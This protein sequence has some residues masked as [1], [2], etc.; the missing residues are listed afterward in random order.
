M[1]VC[2]NKA[3]NP[4]ITKEELKS[5]IYNAIDLDKVGTLNNLWKTYIKPRPNIV[6]F[7]EINEPL[8]QIQGVDINTLAFAIRIGK[9]NIVKFLI[10]NCKAKIEAMNQIY[11]SIGKTPMDVI[12]EYGHLDLLKYYLPIYLESKEIRSTDFS[13]HEDSL[14]DLSIF[15]SKTMKK[16]LNRGPT[17]IQ[18]ACERGKIEIVDY[19]TDYFK[20]K[21][22]PDEFN[23]HFED[24][25]TGENCALISC[26]NGNLV[27]AMLLY[28]KCNA[29]FHKLNKRSENAVQLAAIGANKY[30]YRKYFDLIKFLVE[31]LEVDIAYQ[32][33]ETLMLSENKLITSYLESKLLQ[34]G[35]DKAKKKFIEKENAIKQETH[36]EL[37]GLS[38]EIIDRLASAGRNF[39]FTEIFKEELNEKS[40]SSFVSSIS[41]YSEPSEISCPKFW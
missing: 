25:R 12:C 33:E 3:I 11:S 10:E 32:Y 34:R 35:L 28:K 6:P 9:T 37:T 40:H 20:E 31:D 22:V 27:L 19:L 7:F 24:E 16:S 5:K 14:E 29:N 15:N 26:R 41:P 21:S 13:F 39:E 38:P 1:G 30:P 36:D 8:L 17:A 18:R 23:V 2:I 4:Q